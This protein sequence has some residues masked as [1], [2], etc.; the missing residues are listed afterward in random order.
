LHGYSSFK[1]AYP[2]SFYGVFVCVF[3]LCKDRLDW[4]AWA[5]KRA[6]EDTPSGTW[7]D[8]IRRTS[9]ICDLFFLLLSWSGI[10]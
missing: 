10:L 2:S 6:G 8:F 3:Y 1:L 4:M 9:S 5:D 7:D